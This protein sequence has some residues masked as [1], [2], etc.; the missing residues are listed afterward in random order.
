MK[1]AEWLGLDSAVHIVTAN[2][3]GRD[4]CTETT[5]LVWKWNLGLAGEKCIYKRISS[6][7]LFLL[8]A[9][10]LW[11]ERLSFRDSQSREALSQRSCRWRLY[12]WPSSSSLGR[13]ASEYTCPECRCGFC[14]KQRAPCRGPMKAP[15]KQPLNATWPLESVCQST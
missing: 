3:S 9:Q 10:G 1:S 2:L 4:H 13:L 5:P 15:T 11:E 14:H 7:G 6:C 8:P 12:S